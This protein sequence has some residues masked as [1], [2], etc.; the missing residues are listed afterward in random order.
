M[1]WAQW[2][3]IT[4]DFLREFSTLLLIG[5]L[6][7]RI[8]LL[9]CLERQAVYITGFTRYSIVCI[10][11][12][13]A[14]QV[15]RFGATLRSDLLRNT[16]NCF[17]PS[18]MLWWFEGGPSPVLPHWQI[19]LSKA[20]S[21]EYCWTYRLMTILLLSRNS[22]ILSAHSNLWTCNPWWKYFCQ[23]FTSTCI[24]AL[25]WDIF[26]LFDEIMFYVL[27]QNKCGD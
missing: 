8:N 5:W 25:F 16:N 14:G 24:Y 22:G 1:H 9:A 26:K 4:S 3:K 20:L 7:S 13:F 18:N 17:S 10:F 15:H 2:G 27:E 19:D 23:N 12:I 11:M 21:S 6:A